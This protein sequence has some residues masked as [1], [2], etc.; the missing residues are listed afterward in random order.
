MNV[1]LSRQ[2]LSQ[3]APAGADHRHARVVAAALNAQDEGRAAA[4]RLA[5]QV[6]GL[7]PWRRRQLLR[8]LCRRRR[9]AGGGGGGG[10]MV[11]HPRAWRRS[12]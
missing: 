7:S 4:R 2:R 5:A 1:G 3:H 12:R 6:S 10:G 9:R 8:L 11:S